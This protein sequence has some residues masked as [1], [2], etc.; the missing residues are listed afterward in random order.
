MAKK[1]VRRRW[2][3]VGF[4]KEGPMFFH[5][6]EPLNP[7]VRA[8]MEKNPNYRKSDGDRPYSMTSLSPFLGPG[9]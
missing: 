1:K 7:K 2:I 3:S 8:R 9:S 6:Q 4:G 5:N